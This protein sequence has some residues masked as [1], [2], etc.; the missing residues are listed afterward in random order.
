MT[1]SMLALLSPAALA[2]LRHEI[3]SDD[4][5]NGG[6]SGKGDAKTRKTAHYKRI[7]KLGVAARQARKEEEARENARLDRAALCDGTA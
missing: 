2:R 1:D 3:H 5:R 4:G 7:S 6:K